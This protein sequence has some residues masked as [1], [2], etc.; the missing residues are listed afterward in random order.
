MSLYLLIC[1]LFILFIDKANKKYM[2]DYDKNKELSY[3]Q[4]SDVN[5]LYGWAVCQKLPVKNFERIKYISQF[6]A[7]FM[8]NYNEESDGGYFHEVD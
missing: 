6:N 3:I 7:D 8:K 1:I 2:R 5:S 4:Y